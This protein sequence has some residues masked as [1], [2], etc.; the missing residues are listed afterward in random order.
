MDRLT[1]RQLIMNSD[2]QLSFYCKVSELLKLYNIPSIGE[3]KAEL[4]SK[5]HFKQ[6]IKAAVNIYWTDYLQETIQ[7]KSTLN[8]MSTSSLKVGTPHPIWKTLKCTVSDVKKG[9]TKCRMLTGTYLLQ[10]NKHKFKQS[11]SPI[12]RCCGSEPEDIVHMMTTC[13]S[14]FYERKESYDKIKQCVVTSIGL[15]QWNNIFN[16]KT[17]IT[18]LILDCTHFG[19]ILSRKDI[20]VVT[21]LSTELCHK[22][23]VKRLYSQE[24]K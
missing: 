24:M 20:N 15:N 22:L 10:V 8:M 18:K 11:N 23:H 13:S 7:D 6:R 5:L 19:G 2:N 3:L 21:S 17:T 4:P 9:I 12:C 1:E 14:L 16:D